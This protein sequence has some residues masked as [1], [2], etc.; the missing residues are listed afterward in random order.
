MG[1]N[2]FRIDMPHY[3]DLYLEGKL[4]LDLIHEKNV[5]LEHINEAF[6]ALQIGTSSRRTIIF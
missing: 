3:V 4:K 1:S 5:E 2:Q 6:D